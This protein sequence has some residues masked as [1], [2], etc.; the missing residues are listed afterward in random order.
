[1]RQKKIIIDGAGEAAL[2]FH[3]RLGPPGSQ[4]IRRKKKTKI[5]FWILSVISIHNE[6][7]FGGFYSGRIDGF[8]LQMIEFYDLWDLNVGLGG[9]TSK[10]GVLLKEYITFPEENNSFVVLLY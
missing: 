4:P 6:A 10:A 5:E 2:T 9:G 7:S 3:A 1:M 8:P